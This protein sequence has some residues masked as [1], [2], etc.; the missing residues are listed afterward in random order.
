MSTIRIVR[1]N[2]ETLEGERCKRYQ[3][4]NRGTYNCGIHTNGLIYNKNEMRE[5]IVSDDEQI[6]VDNDY[7]DTDEEESE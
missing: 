4:S 7:V 2:G 1:C 5:F 3:C 6:E